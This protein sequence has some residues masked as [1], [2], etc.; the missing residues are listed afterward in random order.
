M[1]NNSELD[2]NSAPVDDVTEDVEVVIKSNYYRSSS[3]DDTSK[4]GCF[5]NKQ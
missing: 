5:R 1:Q 3:A 2:T 4:K